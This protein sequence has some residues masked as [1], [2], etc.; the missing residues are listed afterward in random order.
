MRDGRVV[1]AGPPADIVAT[2]LIKEVFDLSCVIVPDPVTGTPM[3][4]PDATV[5]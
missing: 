1:A 2:A 3:I 5:G 4:V